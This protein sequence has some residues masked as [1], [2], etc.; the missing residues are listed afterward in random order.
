MHRYS[1]KCNVVEDKWVNLLIF[2][3]SLHRGSRENHISW[4]MVHGSWFTVH[5]SRFM[6][7]IPSAHR[8]GQTPQ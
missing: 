8:R 1:G 2:F 5:G 4:F 3:V 7:N 6:D